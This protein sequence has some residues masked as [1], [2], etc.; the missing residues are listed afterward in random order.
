MKPYK[1][2][3]SVEFDLRGMKVGQQF[4]GCRKCRLQIP[5]GSKAHPPSIECPNCG[6]TMGIYTV[7][8]P[9]VAT[10]VKG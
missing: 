2:M 4:F 9:S 7:V 3:T 5:F 10:V 1:F 6:K 8:A